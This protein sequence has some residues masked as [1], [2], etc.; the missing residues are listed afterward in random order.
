MIIELICLLVYAQLAEYAAHRWTMHWPGLGKGKWWHDHAVEHHARRKHWMN[1]GITPWTVLIA[2]SPMLI[3]ALWLGWVW[4]AIV[5]VACLAYSGTWSALHS[6]HHQNG[7]LRLRK[8]P[9]YGYWEEHH[10][11]H[12]VKPTRNYAAVFP[13][14]DRMFGT[15]Y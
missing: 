12:H 9:G 8:L 13:W 7:C 5:V 15:K 1:I 10:L 14:V 6:A 4:V 3:P 11:D 2:C